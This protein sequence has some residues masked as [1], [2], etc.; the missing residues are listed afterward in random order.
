M[1]DNV[2]MPLV[3][4]LLNGADFSNLFFALDGKSYAS[5]EEVVKA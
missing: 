2:I 4:M 1:V 3:G 5:L